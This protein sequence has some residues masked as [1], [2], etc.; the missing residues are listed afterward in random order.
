MVRRCDICDLLSA[1]ATGVKIHKVKSHHESREQ[2]FTGTCVDK[3]AKQQ[4]SPS[5]ENAKCESSKKIDLRYS[6]YIHT[7]N[8]F[9]YTVYCGGKEI[10][11]IF[12]SKYLGTL[13]MANADH[14]YDVKA[15]IAQAIQR[16]DT[17]HHIFDPKKIS[18][19]CLTIQL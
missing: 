18:L 15:R 8:V 5:P 7:C 4:N 3:T 16:C 19:V 14:M 12:C 9:E 10:D 6:L 1:F 11:N 17:L 2:C 13:S